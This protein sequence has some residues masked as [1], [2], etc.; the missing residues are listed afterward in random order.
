M[1][2]K[3][4]FRQ[5]A[6]KTSMNSFHSTL[7]VT[8]LLSA[9]MSHAALIIYEPFNDTNATVESNTPGTGLTG[10]YSRTS[11]SSPGFSVSGTSLSY[12][13]QTTSGGSASFV[14]PAT[15]ATGNM[16]NSIST[17]TSGPN[18]LAGN[19]LLADGAT[20]WFSVLQRTT[21]DTIHD[22]FALALGTDPLTNNTNFTVAA[23]QGVGFAISSTGNLTARVT[24]AAT[25]H[26]NGT[27]INRFLLAETILI[28]GRITWG[29]TSDT[30]DLYLPDT[31]M[32]LGAIQSTATA[33]VD[34]SVF[35]TLSF[36]TRWQ[37]STTAGQNTDVGLDEIRFG[38]SLSS[39]MIPEPSSALLG[40][41]GMLALLHRRRR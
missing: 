41:L 12:G 17:L 34:Q 25:T 8:L 24:T 33:N 21:N 5:N 32:N 2:S 18:S 13:S 36:H 6:M 14:A 11:S 3:N 38:S 30:V 15:T 1:L 31:S 16:T 28:V 39:V 4:K 37:G 26:A 19:G 20:L 23:A 29:A 40:V 10:T 7:L 27:N 22:G 9:G 35:D